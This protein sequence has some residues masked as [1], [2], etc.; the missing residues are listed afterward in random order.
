MKK[1]IYI[2]SIL[3]VS[4]GFVSCQKTEFEELIIS[5]ANDNEEAKISKEQITSFSDPNISTAEDDLILDDPYVT[6]LVKEVSDGDEESDDD[7]NVSS[8]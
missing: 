5:T 3:A 8:N 7:E 4:I 6:G 1:R 2:A